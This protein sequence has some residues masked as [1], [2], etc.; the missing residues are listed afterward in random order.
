MATYFPKHTVQW[1]FEEPT[2]LRRFSISLVEM[3]L[4][5]GVVMRLYRVLVNTGGAN[6]SW[7]WVGGSFAFGLLILCAAATVHLANYPLQRWVVRAPLFALVEAAAESA[8]AL[9]LIWFGRELWGSA[10]AVWSDWLPMSIYTVWTRLV[11]VCGWALILAAVVWVVRRTI[12]REQKV[13]E[14]TVEDAAQA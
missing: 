8:T 5:T 12:L 14:D 1:H 13:E 6:S 2:I 7:L 9:V 11:I 4:L 10:R 3:A